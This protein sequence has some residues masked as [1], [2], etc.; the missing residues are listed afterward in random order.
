MTCWYARDD[1]IWRNIF[2]NNGASADNGAMPDSDAAKQDRTGPY[3]N[4]IAY[5]D[6][7]ATAFSAE[8]RLG[9]SEVLVIWKASKS[10]GV[11]RWIA[12]KGVGRKPIRVVVA[13]TDDNSLGNGAITSDSRV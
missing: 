2:G 11:A 12:H 7:V 6:S 9:R 3:P 13:R 8:W 10:T 5:Y 1:F 4:I